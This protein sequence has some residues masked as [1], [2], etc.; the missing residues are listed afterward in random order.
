MGIQEEVCIQR[1]FE[2]LGLQNQYA[3]VYPINLGNNIF[4]FLATL[5]ARLRSSLKTTSGITS[6]SFLSACKCK[7]SRRPVFAFGQA[8]CTEIFQNISEQ[9][10]GAIPLNN[11]KI[12]HAESLKTSPQIVKVVQAGK[13]TLYQQA[14]TAFVKKAGSRSFFLAFFLSGVLCQNPIWADTDETLDSYILIRGNPETIM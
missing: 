5:H 11:T 7:Y 3:W 4:V 9:V 10:H 2:T 8:V 6:R 13:E 12:Y 1:Y 14:W